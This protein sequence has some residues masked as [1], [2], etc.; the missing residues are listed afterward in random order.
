VALA[1]AAALEFRLDR[2]EREANT[3]NPSPYKIS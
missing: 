3:L 1:L 2:P